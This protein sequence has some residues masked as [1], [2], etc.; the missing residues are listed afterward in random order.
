M[1]PLTHTLVGANL[2]ATRL[3][4]KT[5]LAAP[6]L[7]IGANLPDLDAIL[8]FTGHDDLALGFRR[9][10]TH[11][12]LALVALPLFLSGLLLL[13]SRLR[14]IPARPA[15]L[16]ALSFLAVLTHPALDWLNTYGMR[17]LM[18]FDG[19]WSY[20]DS[21]Y[22]M[23][24]WLWLILGFFWL[25][26]R[27]ATAPIV[28]IFLL[29]GLAVGRVVMR[30]SPE[31]LIVIAAVAVVLLIGLFWR[32]SAVSAVA[33]STAAIVIAGGYI[34]ARLLIHEATEREIKRHLGA[35]ERIMAA[36]H[37]I[38]PTRWTFV[39]QTR[40]WY[41]HGQYDWRSRT[42]NVNPERIPLPLESPEWA[43][44]RRH[45]SIR[46]FMTWVRFPWYEVEYTATETRV[47][48]NDARRAARR[49]RG[50]R[51]GVVVVLPAR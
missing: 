15:W 19:R 47:Y 1:D 29:V 51:G 50:G 31:D 28:V 11:G 35:V 3:G 13:Y 2:A 39:A 12:I 37:P 48:I 24:P 26:G 38:D 44:A 16:L 32:P 22:I 18:P 34:A 8:Y 23:D 14:R 41:R 40:D 42:L 9:G 20:G 25:A 5:S 43:A 21:V 7:I 10:W 6:A 33:L 49:G 27:K 17:W 45:P 4:R 36:P 46:G 30:R